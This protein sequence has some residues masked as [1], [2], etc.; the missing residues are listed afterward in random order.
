MDKK[1]PFAGRDLTASEEVE[2]VSRFNLK[3]TD[4]DVYGDIDP[5]TM[6]PRVYG[7]IDPD[8]QLVVYDLEHVAEHV[9]RL[10]A[11]DGTTASYYELPEGALELQDIIS[12]KNMNAQM[13][14]IFRATMR[15]GEVEHSSKLRDINKILFYAQEEKKR[16]ERY[17]NE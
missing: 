5:K 8:K 15:Y 14:E 10:C 13:G 9:D 1:M 4:L 3:P 2:R 17:E 6:K 11:S 7:P 16:L 12:Y